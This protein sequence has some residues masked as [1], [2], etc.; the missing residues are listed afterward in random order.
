IYVSN[1]T[2]PATILS[3]V[4]HDA[5]HRGASANGHVLVPF[6]DWQ[7]GIGRLRLGADH[8]TVISAISAIGA[9]RTRHP[10]RILVGH[11]ER[12]NRKRV[13]MISKRFCG[14]AEQTA[15]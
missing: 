6:D 12:G 5:A 2:R 11:A 15:K 1:A 3:T 13:R 9:A 8:A 4:V 10:I 14:V 7:K